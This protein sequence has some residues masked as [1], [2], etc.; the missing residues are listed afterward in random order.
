MQRR[1]FL[2]QSALAGAA[3]SLPNILT[4]TSFSK[5]PYPVVRVPEKD[6]HFTSPVIEKTIRKMQ[7]KINDSE[8]AW[9]FG[10]CFPNTLDTTVEYQEI[11][12]RPD[13]F[14]ITGDIHA[15]W[16]RDSSA[17][18]W[19]YLSFVNQDE[20]LKKLIAGV[21]NRQSKCILIDPY[22]NA[23]NKKPIGSE[24][25][26]D[27]TEMNP[28][29]HERKY[30]LDSL[31]YPIRLA[32]NYWKKTNDNSP[33]DNTW[34]KAMKLAVK[35]MKEQQRKD[36]HGPYKFMRRTPIATDTMTGRGYG[37]PVKPVGL[38]ASGFRPSDDAT[39]YLFLIP[40]NLFAVKSLQQL[41]EMSQDIQNDSSFSQECTALANEVNAAIQ[42]Y[43]VQEYHDFGKIYAFEVDGYGNRL[44]IDDAN[45]PSLLAIPYLNQDLANDPIY[46]NTRRFIM[47]DSNPYYFKS[48]FAEGNGS[49]HTPYNYIWPMSIIMR[50]MTS[51]DPKEIKQCL[52]W[53]KTTH[54]DTGFMHESFNKDNPKEFTR[55]WFAWTNTLFGELV[56]K[57]ENEHPKLLKD[58]DI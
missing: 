53:L 23:F 58:S 57:V 50:A 49:P 34:L 11:D 32:Y 5:N 21:I 15:M 8:L 39:T 4:A 7:R 6:R 56:L 14:V 9:L 3:L 2:Q 13:T 29:I 26:T 24:W 47:S 55:K 48:K 42:K 10:N 36:G 22:A 1:K 51:T 12:G 28:W 18:V 19:P 46:Q 20:N 38:I 27:L 33:F 30:E 43:A 16:L 35:T 25:E 45:I 54:A 40:S 44:F 37:N 31:C 41:A 52:H 17:Q